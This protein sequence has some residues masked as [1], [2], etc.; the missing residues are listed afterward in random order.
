M[1]SKSLVIPPIYPPSV[2]ATNSSSTS[3]P[4]PEPVQV[5]SLKLTDDQLKSIFAAQAD[6]SVELSEATI[7][8]ND[9]TGEIKT[10][11]DEIFKFN[12]RPIGDGPDSAFGACFSRRENSVR[13]VGC[14]SAD[15]EVEQKM[16]KKISATTK[17]RTLEAATKSR[18]L[19]I[20]E[21]IPVRPTKRLRGR[22]KT[23]MT[24]PRPAHTRRT[25][26][27]SEAPIKVPVASG[28][29]CNRDIPA[30]KSCP[31]SVPS[32]S[33]TTADISTTTKKRTLEAA[34]AGK[35]REVEIIENTIV[36]P[37]KRRCGQKNTVEP[38]PD[39]VHTRPTLKGIPS[40]S[41]RKFRPTGL[42]SVPIPRPSSTGRVDINPQ[43]IAQP[44]A[45]SSRYPSP[46][47][48]ISENIPMSDRDL[49]ISLDAF[50]ETTTDFSATITTGT[51]RQELSKLYC[52]MYPIYLNIFSRLESIRNLFVNLEKEYQEANALTRD[53]VL[54]S[55]NNAYTDNFPLYERL[56]T[57]F[58]IVHAKLSTIKRSL[59]AYKERLGA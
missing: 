55:I 15:I 59:G 43:N 46:I 54:E 42:R 58:P 45:M 7:M 13:T 6:E 38:P 21:D 18:V 3:A 56:S 10:V 37:T 34:N 28:S 47:E 40:T 12:T 44:N 20:T 19:Q 53:S 32:G 9:D 49:Y 30:K 48:N 57:A 35:S 24:L 33:G 1:A 4:I 52:E 11:N 2:P 25:S 8:F 16:N 26:G 22:K 5:Y 17:K 27:P 39:H 31:S 50:I 36:P 41:K 23:V 51:Q 29:N 14:I